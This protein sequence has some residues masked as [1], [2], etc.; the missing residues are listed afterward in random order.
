[1]PVALRLD[2]VSKHY[3][4]NGSIV[5]ALDR[6]TFEVPRGSLAVVKGPSGSGKTTLIHLAAGLALPTSGC[7]TVAGEQL[8]RLS[9]RRR[10]ALR[11]RRVAVVFQMFHLVPYLSAL[12]NTLLPTLAAPGEDSLARAKELL[13]DLGIASR[14]AHFPSEMSVGERQR[15]AV[16]RALLNRPEVILADE[17]TGNLDPES[18][19]RVLQMLKACRNQGATVLL[20]THQ[21]VE[22][23]Q[24]DLQLRLDQGRLEAS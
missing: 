5:R 2:N 20:V 12:E 4:K 19:Q 8:E 14:A 24:P 15:C 11:A 7:V 17:P 13:E 1:M 21:A 9:P 6:V 18:A 23:I 22:E 3:S 10:A 16:A